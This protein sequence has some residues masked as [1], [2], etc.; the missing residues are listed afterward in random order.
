MHSIEQVVREVKGQKKEV[1]MLFGTG[2][3][4]GDPLVPQEVKG[5]HKVLRGKGFSIAFNNGKDKPATFYPLVFWDKNAENM[6]KLGFKGQLVEVAGRIEPQSYK[7]QDGEQKSFDA[8]V[9]DRFEVRQYKDN[10]SANNP[11]ATTQTTKQEEP[12]GLSGA[13]EAGNVGDDDIPF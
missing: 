11:P 10:G 1:K 6:A 9:V 5:G 4:T 12:Q 2:R 3:L 13:E 8:L 7:A